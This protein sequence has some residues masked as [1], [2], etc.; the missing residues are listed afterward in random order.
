MDKERQ[1]RIRIRV[2][3]FMRESNLSL[4][5]L[6][7]RS[8][9]PEKKLAQ[10]L[11]PEEYAGTSRQEFTEADLYRL[12][13]ATGREKTEFE[14]SFTPE[15]LAAKEHL[16]W[17]LR[18][19]DRNDLFPRL[20]PILRSEASYRGKKGKPFSD[21]EIKALI[22]EFIDQPKSREDGQLYLGFPD[23]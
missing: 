18:F 17:H 22:D 12:A 4:P 20:W 3:R 16:S 14:D 15:E 10:L 5:Q 21:I 8:G 9:V 11:I 2:K 19:L 7:D 23:D 1:N 13:Y 6:A